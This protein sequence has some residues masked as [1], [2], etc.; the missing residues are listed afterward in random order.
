MVAVTV[1]MVVAWA[2]RLRRSGARSVDCAGGEQRS[3]PAWIRIAIGFVTNFFDTLGVGSYATTTTIF[4]FLKTVDD[5]VIPGTLTIGHTLP[6]TLQAFIYITIVRVDMATLVSM[7]AS[8]VSGALLGA[9]VV[10][11]WP[12]RKVQLGMG[13][14][15]LI[16]VSII[17]L[18]Q[19]ADL[20]KEAGPLGLHGNL[21]LI[22]VCVNFLLGVIMTI[23]VGLYAPCMVLTSLLGMQSTAAFPIM[24]GSCAFLMPLAG[25]RFMKA[26]SFSSP[27]AVGLTL[28]GLPGVA[29][30]A[31]LVTSLPVRTINWLIIVVVLYTAISMIVAATRDTPKPQ[32]RP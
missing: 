27:A 23:G 2:L 3:T 20:Q 4:R 21:L 18:R 6:T 9:G 12:R 11:R 30:A 10:A 15:L 19:V 8:A 28:G 1:P 25:L 26:E 5:R 32:V 7:I 17:F 31:W 24:M 14:A 13:C 22:G 16:A 29:L